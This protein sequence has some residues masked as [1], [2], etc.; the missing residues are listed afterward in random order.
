MS[1]QERLQWAGL[2]DTNVDRVYRAADKLHSALCQLDT[3]QLNRL[4]AANTEMQCL[5]DVAKLFGKYDG[6]SR[7]DF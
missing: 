4:K 3:Q 6:I 1:F 5:V 2:V 7:S